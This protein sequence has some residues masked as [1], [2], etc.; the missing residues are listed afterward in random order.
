MSHTIISVMGVLNHFVNPRL[1]RQKVTKR[2]DLPIKR[3]E[4]RKSTEK[5]SKAN[6]RLAPF[7][8]IKPRFIWESR[9]FNTP[10][11]S[12][13]DKIKRVYILYSWFIHIPS[14][15]TAI[16]TRLEL[17]SP[18]RAEPNMEKDTMTATDPDHPPTIRSAQSTATALESNTCK[19][20]FTGACVFLY[21]KIRS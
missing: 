19:Q 18:A 3:L 15:A 20:S 12:L 2:H 1:R 4:M 6:P 17:N 21:S 9:V 7:A 10:L 13:Y 8:T 14:L 11:L 16:R 5:N